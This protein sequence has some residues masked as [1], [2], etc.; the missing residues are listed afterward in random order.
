MKRFAKR[1]EKNG[2][3]IN[4]VGTTVVSGTAPHG[5]W[6]KVIKGNAFNWVYVDGRTVLLRDTSFDGIARYLLNW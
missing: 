1:L 4:E 6:F 2:C 3:R 5:A